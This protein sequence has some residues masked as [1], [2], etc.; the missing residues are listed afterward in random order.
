MVKREAFSADFEA[1]LVLGQEHR[2]NKKD[3][4]YA[5]V[6]EPSD[7]IKASLLNAAN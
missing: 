2:L 1:F 5:N 3:S 6:K 4:V 7:S